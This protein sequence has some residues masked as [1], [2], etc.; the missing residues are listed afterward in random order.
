MKR[1]R[2]RRR[3]IDVLKENMERVGSTKED[4][5]DRVRSRR[6]IHCTERRRMFHSHCVR[7]LNATNQSVNTDHIWSIDD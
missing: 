2:P 7:L 4:A 1:G 3:D 6:I 5:R